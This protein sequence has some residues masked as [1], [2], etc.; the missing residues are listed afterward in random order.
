MKIIFEQKTT[1]Q[2]LDQVIGFLMEWLK[3]LIQKNI[4]QITKQAY[5]RNP[6]I[7]VHRIF[8]PATQWLG[9]RYSKCVTNIQKALE[10][11]T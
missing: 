6:S 1:N 3:C 2:N 7:Y 11:I 5:D 9:N 4:S 8:Q 10:E